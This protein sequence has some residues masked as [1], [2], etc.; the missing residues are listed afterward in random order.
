MFLWITYCFQAFYSLPG[1][2]TVTGVLSPSSEMPVMICNIT[3][4][5]CLIEL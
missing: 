1:G 5:H 2:G 3:Y 4:L